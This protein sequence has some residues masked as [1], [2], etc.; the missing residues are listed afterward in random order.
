M[1]SGIS[2]GGDEQKPP[3]NGASLCAPGKVLWGCKALWQAGLSVAL[4]QAFCLFQR[5]DS[6]DCKDLATG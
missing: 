2:Q 4:F 6:P 1:K 5:G 3:L